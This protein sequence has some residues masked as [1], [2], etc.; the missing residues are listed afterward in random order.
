MSSPPERLGEFI[1]GSPSRAGSTV[2]GLGLDPGATSPA[3]EPLAGLD[4]SARAETARES[5]SVDA[6]GNVQRHT[7]RPPTGTP[8]DV[9]PGDS[10]SQAGGA[11]TPR[12]RPRS[13]GPTPPPT[14]T[15]A[16]RPSSF[17]LRGSLNRGAEA[18]EDATAQ[19]ANFADDHGNVFKIVMQRDKQDYNFTFDTAPKHAEANR[20]K[21]WKFAQQSKIIQKALDKAATQAY[22][23]AIEKADDKG[24]HLVPFSDLAEGLTPDLVNVDIGIFNALSAVLLKE[25]DFATLS[26]RFRNEVSNR[27]GRQAWRMF[28]QKCST[29][30][31]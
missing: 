29:T 23:N 8:D 31:G 6:A 10:V 7:R 22:L 30:A 24:V 13:T 26:Q 25:K 3:R 28:D 17:N 14:P 2:S 18:P 11:G 5:P 15:G 21:D 1:G 9:A 27:C 20:Y 19:T 16:R 12:G 4:A